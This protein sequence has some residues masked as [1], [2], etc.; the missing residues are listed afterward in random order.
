MIRIKYFGTL[1]PKELLAT[2]RD[3][4]YARKMLLIFGKGTP[5]MKL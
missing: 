2:M 4:I 5:R 3:M 1:E